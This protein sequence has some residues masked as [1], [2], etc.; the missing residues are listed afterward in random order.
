MPIEKVPNSLTWSGDHYKDN[1]SSIPAKDLIAMP[2]YDPKILTTPEAQLKWGNA[3]HNLIR[4]A[5]ILYSVVYLGNYELDHQENAGSHLA[6]DIRVPKGTPIQAVANGKVVL[7]SEKTS[8]FGY[9]V[10]IEHP[11]VPDYPENG[12]TTTL[13][14]SYNHL[15]EIKVREGATVKK[16]EIIALS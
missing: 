16:G 2:K 9:Y 3:E 4:N 13:Y 8:G 14:S 10:V 5:K 1:Y 11:N 12:K 7:V 6:V 15:S